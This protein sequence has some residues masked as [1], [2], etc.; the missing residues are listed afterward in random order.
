MLV[1][2][3][4]TG[5]GL[6]INFLHIILGAQTG[7]RMR[8]YFIYDGFL[9]LGPFDLEEIR[10][11]KLTKTTRIRYE[12]ADDWTTVEHMEELSSFVMEEEQPE[13]TI[14]MLSAAPKRTKQIIEPVKEEKKPLK[15]RFPLKSMLLGI[16]LLLG[17]TIGS[18]G[19]F[20]YKPN[21]SIVVPAYHKPVKKAVATTPIPVQPEP[22]HE[23]EPIAVP[24]V[25]Q[26]TQH[27]VVVNDK[28]KEIRKNWSKYITANNTSYAYGVLGGIDNLSVKFSN[29]TDYPLDVVTAKVTYVKANG[30]PWKSKL[31]SIYNIPPHSDKE[32]P[33]PKVSRG[34]SVQVTI[35][36]ITSRKMHFNYAPGRL[37]AN[38]SDPYY[39]K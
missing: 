8:Q 4:Y 20:S 3:N 7:T 24:E 36:K 33:L 2:K 26:S 32:E 31:V 29:N 22:Q 16:G 17:I 39:S 37:T 14:I 21:P 35:Q 15:E 13:Q 19:V 34:K 28:A 12:D 23:T 38:P 30:K 11:Q 9:E 25:K 10:E 27:H 1:F 18:V 6:H 5:K